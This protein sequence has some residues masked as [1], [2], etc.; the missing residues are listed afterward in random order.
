LN[1]L[2]VLGALRGSQGFL[3]QRQH[4]IREITLFY[5]PDKETCN[6]FCNIASSYFI[7]HAV[8]S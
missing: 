6:P 8:D 1:F 2:R 5:E 3:Q 4:A 7:G